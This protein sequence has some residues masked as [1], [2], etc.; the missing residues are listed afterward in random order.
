MADTKED[1]DLSSSIATTGGSAWT[2]YVKVFLPA[3]RAADFTKEESIFEATV[4]K[5]VGEEVWKALPME[6]RLNVIR[7]NAHEKERLKVTSESAK[8]IYE[9]RL[10]HN[11]DKEALTAGPLPGSEVYYACWPSRVAGLDVYGHPILYD[12][13]STMDFQKLCT[14]DEGDVYHFRTQALES[15]MYLKA[16]VSAKLGLRV[17]KHVYVLD[18]AGLES[19]FFSSTIQKKMRAVMKM[20]ADMFPETLWTVWLVNAPTSFRLI[21]SVIRNWLDPMIRSK[22]RMWGSTKS[23]WHAAMAECGIPV[24]SLPQE[25]GGT[26]PS[27]GLQDILVRAAKANADKAN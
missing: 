19:S 5:V 3:E 24:S 25:F 27:E 26:S 12:R 8:K 1:E 6:I 2:N 15:L 7:G 22:V 9:W 21:W 14:M 13:Y 18:L 17:C 11:V 10:K 20:S 4:I 23:K 16:E